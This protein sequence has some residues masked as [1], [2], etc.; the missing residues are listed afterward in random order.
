MG[1]RTLYLRRFPSAAG[2]DS[3]AG[4]LL[5]DRFKEIS[6]DCLLAHCVMG[7]DAASAVR[8][9]SAASDIASEGLVSRL[10]PNLIYMEGGL[11]LHPEGWRIPEGFA[12]DF[13][14]DGGVIVIADVDANEA[15]QGK[16]RYESA[17]DFMGC[18]IDYGGEE[19]SPVYGADQRYFWKSYR[20]IVMRPDR[21]IVSDW[22]RP[23][24]DGITEITAGLP[25]RLGYWENAVASGN[26]GSTGTL[27]S[28]RWVDESDR[29]V[30]GSVRTYG[31]GYIA[32]LAANVSMDSI[33]EA[34]PDNTTW[35][36]SLGAFLVAE[37]ASERKRNLSHLKSR[38]QLFL[39]H[40]GSDADSVAEVARDLRKAGLAVWLDREKLLP[41]R[42]IWG[43]ISEGLAGMTHFVLFWSAA[44]LDGPGVTREW[45]AATA[46]MTERHIPIIIVRLD[47][48]SVPAIMADIFRIEA[49]GLDA[50]QVASQITNAVD[51]L[52]RL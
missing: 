1:L 31:K 10:S 15:S 35:L 29:C 16:R 49:A 37:A 23:A 21:M 14:Q 40:R 11:L 5:Y 22:L 28:D 12:R 4:R 43:G 20:Q 48:A 18:S 27:Q 3:L 47:Q 42:S 51:R 30:F 24:Y 19:T 44:C 8:D 17:R 13:A 38:Q 26:V 36:T 34:Y 9:P 46:A 25:V 7:D 41:S 6:D 45:Q 52:Q 2:R 32:V 50:T 33:A 39:S